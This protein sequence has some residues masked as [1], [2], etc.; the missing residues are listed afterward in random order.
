MRDNEWRD[1]DMSEGT[2]RSLRGSC[3]AKRRGDVNDKGT[4]PNG[5]RR[6]RRTTP[7]DGRRS[8]DELRLES[9]YEVGMTDRFFRGG[10][11]R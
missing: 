5:Q 11:E 8:T 1:V 3:Q 2:T 4:G 6:L 7:R 10:S 9:L